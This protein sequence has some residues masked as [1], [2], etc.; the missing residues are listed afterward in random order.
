MMTFSGLSNILQAKPQFGM[1]LSQQQRTQRKIIEDLQNLLDVQKELREVKA[2]QLKD[3]PAEQF[4]GLYIKLAMIDVNVNR[5]LRS[6]R[7]GCLA[8][9]TQQSRRL[10]KHLC[11]EQAAN[12]IFELSMMDAFIPE[13]IVAP[14]FQRAEKAF[15]PTQRHELRRRYEAAAVPIN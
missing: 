10:A 15:T 5:L 9:I 11:P 6:D 7:E 4:S 13:Y 8:D 12:L 14:L 3:K 1:A 2:V